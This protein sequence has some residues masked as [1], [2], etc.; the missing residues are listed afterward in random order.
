MRKDN[1]G[2]GFGKTR[3]IRLHPGDLRGA[4]LGPSGRHVVQR[5]EMYPAVIEPVTGRSHEFAKHVATVERRVVLAR[6]HLDLCT[7]DFA[8]DLLEQPEALCVLV[9]RV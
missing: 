6:R 8:R 7:A 3:E 2:R 1:D 5:D 4:D 9:S